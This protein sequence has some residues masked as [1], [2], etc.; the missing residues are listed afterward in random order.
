MWLEAILMKEDL[1]KVLT[2][3]AP[4]EFR[5]GDSGRLLLVDP[6][7]VSL[8]PDKGLGVVCEATLHWPLL[9]IDVP[10]HI[11]EL[12][13]LIHP[14]VE[15]REGKEFLVFTLTIEHAGVGILPKIVDDKI[16]SMVN[17]ELVKKHVELAW[18]FSETLSHVFSLPEVLVSTAA[19]GLEVD[20]GRVKVTDTALGFAVSFGTEVTR[21][22]EGTPN[23]PRSD[24]VGE[25][26]TPRSDLVSEARPRDPA[27]PALASVAS[28][29]SVFRAG[30]ALAIL[31]LAT[32][33]A[34]G[35][36]S[37]GRR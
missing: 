31:A 2:Q 19:F 24:V 33:F 3:F 9:G 34:L 23:S 11:H 27:R 20:A 12:L 22:V 1:H 10:V 32:A 37:V 18:N 14:A 17:E 21:R 15:Q 29:G 4:M 5:L 25:G 35:R 6:K 8:I 36:A 26:E 28:A 7:D 16:T 13:L 30:G